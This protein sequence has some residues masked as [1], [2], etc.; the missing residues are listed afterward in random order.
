MGEWGAPAKM[1]HPE[2]AKGGENT[3]WAT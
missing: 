3:K 2:K 1:V